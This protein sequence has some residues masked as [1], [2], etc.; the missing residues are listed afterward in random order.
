[1]ASVA[2]DEDSEDEDD[3][4]VVVDRSR[5]ASGLM[6]IPRLPE[7]DGEESEAEQLGAGLG[8]MSISPTRITNILY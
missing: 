7:S 5:P 1:M 6:T 8:R 2:I 3:E 4:V